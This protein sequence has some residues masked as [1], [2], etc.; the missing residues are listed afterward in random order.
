MRYCIDSRSLPRRVSDKILH[1]YY[2]FKW[3]RNNLGICNR[4]VFNQVT[5]NLFGKI[6]KRYTIKQWN[7]LQQTFFLTST[8]KILNIH[9][10]YNIYIH[11]FFFS[12]NFTLYLKIKSFHLSEETYLPMIHQRNFFNGRKS[13]EKESGKA[14]VFGKVRDP[15]VPGSTS[16][17]WTF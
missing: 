6:E 16:S 4:L 10:F 2:T 5:P 1:I 3:K 13:I 14:D 15:I 8:F 11:T 17:W 7:I 12:N 9:I